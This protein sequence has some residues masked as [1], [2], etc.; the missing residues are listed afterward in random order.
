MSDKRQWW[1][2]CRE[3][4]TD[5]TKVEASTPKL[6]A[7]NFAEDLDRRWGNTPGET[8]VEVKRD[9]EDRVITFLVTVAVTYTYVA[10]ETP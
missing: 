1:C 4:L 3:S 6:A 8:R 9:R 2:R 7:Q 5:W 10:K